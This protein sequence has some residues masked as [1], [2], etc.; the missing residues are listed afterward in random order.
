M[1]RILRAIAFL[2]GAPVSVHPDGSVY[3]RIRDKWMPV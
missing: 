2:I 1:K 3:V